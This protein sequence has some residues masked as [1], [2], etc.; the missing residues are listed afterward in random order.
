MD[1]TIIILALATCLSTLIGGAVAIRLRK[2]LHY[3]FAFSAG[4]LVA[5]AFLDLLPES[6]T[7]A[8]AFGFPIRYVFI[9]AV[10][11]FLFY[12]IIERAFA[13]HHLDK[14][15]KEIAH[16]HIMGPIG[17]SGL[18]IHSFLDGIA[19]GSAFQLGP[20]AGV[21]VAFAVISHD[22]T[23]GINTVIVMFKNLHTKKNAK[24]ALVLD[25]V[26]PVIGILLISQ[27][28]IS[29]IILA[30]ILA[31]FVGEFIYLGASNI[32]PE[33]RIHSPSKMMLFMGLGIAV[34]IVLTSFV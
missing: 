4:A 33:T 3:F 30:I 29:P 15:A 23:D 21:I 8:Q 31:I 18:I 14:D 27:F 1:T 5:V 9:A 7:T 28:Q 11:S 22:F 10:L 17:A 13:T 26:A 20:I 34:I 6:I 24:I 32:L 25:A 2:V 19:I 16:S 12:N